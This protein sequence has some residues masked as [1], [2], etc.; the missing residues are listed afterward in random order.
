MKK[1]SKK[2]KKSAT[3]KYLYLPS[4]PLSGIST[5]NFHQKTIKNLIRIQE[6]KEISK[7]GKN[8]RNHIPKKKKKNEMCHPKY[9]IPSKSFAPTRPKNRRKA[10]RK[11]LHN[12][13][14][15]NHQKC[16]EKQHLTTTKSKML[17]IT[18]WVTKTS[19]RSDLYYRL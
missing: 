10:N 3:S 9:P 6:K 13:V 2:R 5:D 17:K 1:Y 11:I 8:R 7:K 15:T 18:K 14:R 12:Q 16:L 4:N 19:K